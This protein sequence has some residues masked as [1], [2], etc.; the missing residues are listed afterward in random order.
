MIKMQCAEMYFRHTS[1][2]LA[3]DDSLQ[4][5]MIIK[6]P[7]STVQQLGDATALLSRKG[8][9]QPF[10]EPAVMPLTIF[11]WNSMKITSIGIKIIMAP[12]MVPP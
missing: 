7:G 4:A 12:A 6:L 11:R 5:P 9:H 10:S 2:E 3:D 8:K 1:K